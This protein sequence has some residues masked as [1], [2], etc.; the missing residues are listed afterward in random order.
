MT[1]KSKISIARPGS[2]SLRATV[3]ESIVQ[4]LELKEG[5]TLEWQMT[6]TPNGRVATVRKSV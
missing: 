3:P 5:D 1:S 4:F 6:D 2:P